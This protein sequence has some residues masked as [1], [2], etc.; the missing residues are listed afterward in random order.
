MMKSAVQHARRLEKLPAVR[1]GLQAAV[2]FPLNIGLT[3]GL[4]ELAGL[5]EEIAFCVSLAVV[6]VINFLVMRHYVYRAGDGHGGRQL[7]GFA[8]TSLSFRAAEYAAF[9]LIHTR[10]GVAYV[11]AMVGI[12]V[13][14]FCAK[15][16][17]F[18]KLVFGSRKRQTSARTP[19]R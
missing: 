6:F 7:A 12:L 13:V 18:G 3:I 16:F 1:F 14:S 5:A 4:H 11:P 10:L 2:G 9:L 8:A 17:V 19:A 15:Y